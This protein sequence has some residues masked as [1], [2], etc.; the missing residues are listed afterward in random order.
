MRFFQ[1][2]DAGVKVVNLCRK[3][4]WKYAELSLTH[5]ALQDAVQKKL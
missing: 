4:R 2:T 1:E 5:Q 3:Y